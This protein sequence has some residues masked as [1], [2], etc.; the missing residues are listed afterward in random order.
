MVGVWFD[1]SGHTIVVV[2]Y[3]AD[4]YNLMPMTFFLSNR[5]AMWP[6]CH[7]RKQWGPAPD[8]PSKKR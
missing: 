1:E 7:D 4:T 6:N 8:E 2:S 3:L 5:N